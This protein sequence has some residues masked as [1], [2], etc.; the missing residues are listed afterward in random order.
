MTRL[1]E[2]LLNKMTVRSWCI[3]TIAAALGFGVIGYFAGREHVKYE[4]KSGLE[5]T[6]RS[7]AESFPMSRPTTRPKRP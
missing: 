1:E 7:L 6:M 4:L 5:S 2:F 3:A